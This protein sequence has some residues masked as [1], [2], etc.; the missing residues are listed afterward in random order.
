MI[1][2]K[3]TIE[4]FRMYRGTSVITFAQP[5]ER[6]V[7]L[8]V[9]ENQA[10]KTTLLH[11]LLWCLYGKAPTMAIP[12]DLVNHLAFAHA[13]FNEEI[14]VEVRLLFRHDDV[15]YDVRRMHKIVKKEGGNRETTETVFRVSQQSSDAGEPS[16][17]PDPVTRVKEILPET[18][19][20]F[21]LFEGEAAKGWSTENGGTKLRQ[22]VEDC[23]DLTMQA[24]AGKHLETVAKDIRKELR[25]LSTGDAADL[26]SKIESLELQKDKKILELELAGSE[27]R[28]VRDEIEKIMEK[29]A[30]IETTAPLVEEKKQLE[31]RSVELKQQVK[32][33]QKTLADHIDKQGFVA[34]SEKV[35]NRLRDLLTR[36]YE[37]DQIPA[38]IKPAFVEELIGRKECI[39]GSDLSDGTFE[40]KRI[41]EWRS[42]SGLGDLSETLA[43]L[44]GKVRDF[45]ERRKANFEADNAVYDAYRERESSLTLKLSNARGRIKDLE[46]KLEGVKGTDNITEL[47]VA[48]RKHQKEDGDLVRRIH[49]LQWD[50]GLGDFSDPEEHPETLEAKLAMA[51]DE[52]S[53]LHARDEKRGRLSE[54]VACAE[55]MKKAV[56]RL[57]TEWLGI[58]QKYLDAK[59]KGS[60]SEVI[61]MTRRVVIDESF[62]LLIQKKVDDEWVPDAPS[63]SNKGVSALC[64]VSAFVDLARKLHEEPGGESRQFFR[65]GLYPMVMDAPYS[66]WDTHF[67]TEVSR[68]L[69]KV[70]PQLVVITKYRDWPVA[71]SVLE[72]KVGKSYVVHF[73]AKNASDKTI[74]L[75]GEEVAY[76]TQDP[77][78]DPEYSMIEEVGA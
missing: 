29:L 24:K 27:Q 50:I 25:N 78:A 7:T 54:Q 44:E 16:E 55:R 18:L 34:F 52:S 49:E 76:T 42:S 3:L 30:S 10:G 77:N 2:Q 74:S 1:L 45:E 6:S 40:R 53:E 63:E 22:S 61:L 11:A 70:V 32:D 66:D 9:G 60:Y 17:V 28:H 14:P 38:K 56:E 41:E 68:H 31:T 5:G 72:T 58:V 51:R 43:V 75:M 39:C 73:T 12:D 71:R 4:N 64:F 47:Q 26:E 48:L 57:R 46:A 59:T 65:G 67:C 33:A 8:L 19:A 36:A 21:F 13:D 35:T 62:Q 23:L 20:P 69:S 15:L 37:K